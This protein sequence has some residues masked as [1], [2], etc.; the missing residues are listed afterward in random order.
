MP[1]VKDVLWYTAL[2]YSLVCRASSFTGKQKVYK[3]VDFDYLIG[4]TGNGDVNLKRFRP[5]SDII[6]SLN[7]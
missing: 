3:K 5:M 6:L 1:K 4:L 2:S 7:D